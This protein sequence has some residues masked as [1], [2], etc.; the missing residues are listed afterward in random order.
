MI[1]IY[2]PSRYPEPI[3]I[4]WPIYP[5]TYLQKLQNCQEPSKWLCCSFILEP[6]LCP[7]WSSSLC[8]KWTQKPRRA[9]PE[10]Q[11]QETNIFVNRSLNI[12][13]RTP[14]YTCIHSQFSVVPRNTCAV[15]EFAPNL[16]NSAMT[17]F[18]ENGD[19]ETIAESWKTYN[20]FKLNST[21]NCSQC[22]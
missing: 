16:W 6:L 2:Y 21:Q 15:S 9:S 20:S 5:G 13:I 8:H 11:V 18:Y 1:M 12:P 19:G 4:F 22:F 7:W 17:D 10:L 3:F 14:S